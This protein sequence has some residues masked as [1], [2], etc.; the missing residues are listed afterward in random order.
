MNDK[1]IGVRL[2]GEIYLEESIE[3]VIHVLVQEQGTVFY[4]VFINTITGEPELSRKI[5]I[6]DVKT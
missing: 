1:F 3:A 4:R 5:T 2:Q 6:E